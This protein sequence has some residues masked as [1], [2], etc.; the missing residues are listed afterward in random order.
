[1][2]CVMLATGD[3]LSAIREHCEAGFDW[4]PQHF[5]GWK[6]RP[7]NRIVLALMLRS[8]SPARPPHHHRISSP[9]NPVVKGLRARSM[10]YWP[11]VGYA[12]ILGAQSLADGG[13]GA[14]PCTVAGPDRIH[15]RPA[16]PVAYRL[17][18]PS[19]KEATRT[20]SG[21]VKWFCRTRAGNV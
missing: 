13:V 12:F 21:R 2:L 20:G 6:A 3:L 5:I 4:K 10:R 9:R 11:P 7:P 8:D 14:T 16:A 18:R 17:R 1:M 19:R 15:F